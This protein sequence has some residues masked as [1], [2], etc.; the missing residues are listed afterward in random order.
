MKARLTKADIQAS[1]KTLPVDYSALNAIVQVETNGAG[2]T[3]DDRPKV[4]FERHKFRANLIAQGYAAQAFQLEK[5]HPNL[6]NIKAGGY[7]TGIDSDARAC[8][9]HDRLAVASTFNRQ[10]AL[11]SCSWGLGQVMGFNWK[12]LGYPSLQTFIN[13]MYASEAQQLDAVCRY[14]KTSPSLLK[15]LQTKDWVTVARLYNGRDYAINHYDTK[16]AAADKAGQ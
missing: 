12:V 15:A 8:A 3:H 5:S 14:I 13:A 10:A 9:E 4:L 7:A 1:A 2:F 16:L 6:C 11:E